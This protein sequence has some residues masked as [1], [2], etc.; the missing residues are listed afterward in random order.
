MDN[1]TVGLKSVAVAGGVR[2][3]RKPCEER[4]ERLRGEGMGIDVYQLD[5]VKRFERREQLFQRGL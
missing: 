2:V 4:V 5:Y 1:C 3:R